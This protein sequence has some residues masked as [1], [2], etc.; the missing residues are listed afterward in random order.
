MSAD[1]GELFTTGLGKQEYEVT[2]PAC[3]GVTGRKRQRLAIV[4]P[5]RGSCVPGLR[6][7]SGTW[8]VQLILLSMLISLGRL[9][10]GLKC[11]C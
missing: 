6:L 11:D 2:G 7:R 9:S 10:E 3:I 1:A 4:F 8:N 5:V